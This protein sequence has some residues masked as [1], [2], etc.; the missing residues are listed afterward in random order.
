MP[1]RNPVDQVEALRRQQAEISGKLKQAEAAER[2]RHKR[3]EQRRCEVAGRVALALL[4]EKPDSAFSRALL[5]ALAATLRRPADRALFPAL[6][7][8]TAA[9]PPDRQATTPPETATDAAA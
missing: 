2:E 5:D 7:P 1:R 6:P 4:H 9:A 8:L 3:E